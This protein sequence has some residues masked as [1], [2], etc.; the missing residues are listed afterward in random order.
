MMEERRK[1]AMEHLINPR[2]RDIQVSGIRKFF[3]KVAE[4]PGAISLTIGQPDFPTPEHVKARAKQAI[5]ENRTTYTLNAGLLELRAAACAF[6]GQRYGL[7]Y[8][9]ATEVIVTNGASEAIDTTLRTILT[10][11]AEVLLPGPVYV[12]Y[13]PII[14]LCGATP[15]YV[16]TRQTGFKM[17]AEGIREKLTERT[18][19]VILPYP[20][21]PT[22]C[23]LS[24]EDLAA[25][26]DVLR[27]RELFVIS[28]EIYSELVFDREHASI[29]QQPGMREKTIVINGLSKS[30][31][32]T[33]WRIGLTFA[34]A[35][36]TQHML[37]VH[38][39]NATCAASISQYAALEALTVGI[40]DAAVMR[41][42]YR[43]RR[44]VVFER[45]IKLGFEVEKPEG[46]FYIFPSIAKW[47][48]SSNE[49][50][51]RLL[52]EGKVAV[53]PGDAFSEY[54][55]GYVRLS[56]ACS[57]EVLNEALDRIEDWLQTL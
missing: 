51:T 18:R 16:D 8:D 7:T 11:G 4:V 28:D 34:P 31:S 14:R 26:A 46:A 29:A 1:R 38:Q 45:L 19:A 40:D 42:E 12:G 24:T 22:G 20:S 32:M 2:V 17:T 43:R 52:Q 55:E 6:L 35:F 54:G 53:V 27:D 23:V 25:I 5:D 15:V 21:N 3:N 10:E 50:A 39:Y 41:E 33:G 47:G 9:P 49:F 44:D 37:K 48:M 56:Y 57:M 13:E 30:H 36:V